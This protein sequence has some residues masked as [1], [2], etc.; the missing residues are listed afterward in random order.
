MPGN[1]TNRLDQNLSPQSHVQ[2]RNTQSHSYMFTQS[3]RNTRLNRNNNQRSIHAQSPSP[4]NKDLQDWRLS[5]PKAPIQQRGGSNIKTQPNA[6]TTL[7]ND[8]GAFQINE[9]VLHY[10]GQ[11][12]TML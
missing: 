8:S 7:T 6:D 4:H 3:P 2:Y 10:N 9:S 12:Q 1:K 5:S 11:D